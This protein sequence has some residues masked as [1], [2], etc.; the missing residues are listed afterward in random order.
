MACFLVPATEAIVTTSIE[1]AM[2]K[3]EESGETSRSGIAFSTKLGWLNKLLWGGS[4]LLAFE[5]VWHGELSP[6]F[7]FLTKMSSP[8]EANEMFHEMATTG[9]GMALLV[10]G[11]WLGMV[12]VSSKLEKKAVEV[13][14]SDEEGNS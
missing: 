7:P 8:S 3:K 1:R 13:S 6:F 10:T 5:H 14:A 2:K 12:V 11:V 4:G 9:V